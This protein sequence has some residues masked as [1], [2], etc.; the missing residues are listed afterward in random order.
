MCGLLAILRTPGAP[1]PA[2]HA[3]RADW[4]L[5]TLAHRGPDGRGIICGPTAWLGHRRLAIVDPEGG[6]QPCLH[7]TMAWVVNGEIYNHQTLRQQ[8]AAAG[9]APISSACDSAVVGPAWQVHGDELPARLDGQFAF[10]AV[11]Q[12][13]GRWI[14]A[15][16]HMGICPLYLGRHADGS[17]WF[18]SEMKALVAD[19]ES[20]EIVPPG[21]AWVGDASGTRCIV[22]DRAAWRTSDDVPTGEADPEH[23]QDLLIDA[24]LKRLMCDV[25]CGLLLSGGLDSSLIAAIAVRRA[26]A[27]AGFKSFSE[28][29]HSFSIGLPGS[30]D[31]VAA[32]QTAEFLGTI[33]HE[34]HFTVDE[35]LGEVPGVVRHLES[36][37]QIR[38]AVP[39]KILARHV[40]EH[41]IK[42]VLSG[43][44][45]DEL[46][47]GYL[48]F[49][50]APS[51]EEMQ[52]ELVRK[53][54]RL[55]LFDVMRA[56]KAPMAHGLEVRFPFLDK[57]FIDHV[58]QLDP[59]HKM[60]DM[61]DRPDGHHARME[62]YLLR[63]A[64]SDAREPWLPESILW[65]R[66]EQFSDGVGYNWVD[67]LREHAAERLTPAEWAGRAER[68]PEATPTS[69]EQY[70]MREVFEAEFMT[71]KAC[72]DSALA[73]VPVGRSLACSTPEAL[74]WDKSWDTLSGD[75]SGR[76]IAGIHPA[77]E[78]FVLDGTA[79]AS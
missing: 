43:E 11:D 6:A 73:T 48:Y 31:L 1:A 56:N 62:K 63:S 71:G 70:W 10:V 78:G 39:T 67:S 28:R 34:I 37:E 65:R 69:H 61:N 54:T 26:S 14:A 68:F 58:M 51:R 20:V 3:G 40:R 27:A 29:F 57:A 44:G 60:I 47:G 53:V 25:P 36:F 16:D 33:H 46:F 64:F 5:D 4:L 79:V 32:R 74:A 52:R 50:K 77:A 2:V 59:R 15:R 7:D 8:L 38:T 75:I 22:W 12:A 45:A 55:H 76:A 19:C 72:A 23:L 21:H 18:A 41:G 13:A 24:V 35:A 66:K 17:I 30:P 9:E 49:H 42:M